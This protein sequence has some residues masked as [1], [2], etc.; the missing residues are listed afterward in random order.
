MR[1]RRPS[2]P[3]SVKGGPMQARNWTEK[4]ICQHLAAPVR[5]KQFDIL[6]G[7]KLSENIN[8]QFHRSTPCRHRG[9]RSACRAKRH[10]CHD[11]CCYAVARGVWHKG[12]WPARVW[13]L[14]WLHM[15]KEGSSLKP[16]LTLRSNM[17]A[18]AQATTRTRLASHLPPPPPSSISVLS[19][20]LKNHAHFSNDT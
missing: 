7:K 9:R 16:S 10:S 13:S 11:L 6:N 8:S 14:S 18:T 15:G 17:N 20:Q 2:G 1:S 12:T 3:W 19:L 4:G 5:H